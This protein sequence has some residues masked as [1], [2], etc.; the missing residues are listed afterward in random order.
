M[1]PKILSVRVTAE[2]DPDPDLSF[3]GE[4][5]DE[6][7]PDSCTIDRKE[8]GDMGRGEKRYFL[9]NI[10]NHAEEDYERMERFARGELASYGI[11]AE[12]I[13]KAAG[14]R[15]TVETP[16]VWGIASDSGGEHASEV[17]AE[18][19]HVLREVL[20]ALG[21]DHSTPLEGSWSEDAPWNGTVT[22]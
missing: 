16:G 12:A 11:R 6:P 7:G 18:Q 14:T 17:A 13:L 1:T 2:P 10:A 20:D 15:Q 8:R 22:E 21:V 9:A 5:S 3:Y 4:Y 19:L